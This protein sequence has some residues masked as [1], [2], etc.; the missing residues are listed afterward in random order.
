MFKINMK[1]F[2]IFGM[3]IVIFC[4]FGCSKKYHNFDTD[5]EKYRYIYLEDVTIIH[6]I[7]ELSQYAYLT[8]YDTTKYDDAYFLDNYLLLFSFMKHY[9]ETKVKVEGTKF[10]DQ[11]LL[12]NISINSPANYKSSGFDAQISSE[13]LF[14]DI[15]KENI[16]ENE[17]FNVGILVINKRYINVYCSVYYDC[18]KED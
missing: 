16:K 14:I 10:I 18:S 2:L 7:E 12:I 3:I 9:S 1:L 15:S 13:L 8:E 11:Q 4:M 5:N 17:D 6:S